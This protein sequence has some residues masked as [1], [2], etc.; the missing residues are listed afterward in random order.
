MVRH[1]PCVLHFHD[2]AARFILRLGRPQGPLSHSQIPP[3][4]QGEMKPLQTPSAS[5][6]HARMQKVAFSPGGLS[7][8]GADSLVTFDPPLTLT[9]THI[10]N[11]INKKKKK[12][13]Y[14][15]DAQECSQ[16]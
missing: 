9:H 13:Y 8:T 15:L 3:E 1:L 2:S 11:C 16:S 10:Q 14:C 4:T 5:D 12:K 7:L 6:T